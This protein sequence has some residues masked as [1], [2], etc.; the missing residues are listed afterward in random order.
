MPVKSTTAAP[1]QGT[2]ATT[3]TRSASASPAK[4]GT[5]KRG[6][7][8]SS[9]NLRPSR[10]HFAIESPLKPST[11]D[12]VEVRPGWWAYMVTFFSSESEALQ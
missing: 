2:A 6:G 1:L 3:K 10:W 4:D 8:A 7:G 12:T 11:T 9:K 5:P